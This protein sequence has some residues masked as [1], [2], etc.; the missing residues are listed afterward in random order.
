[1]SRD[2]KRAR[3]DASGA[4][5]R[6]LVAGLRVFDRYYLKR[7]LGQGGMGVV[8]LAHDRVLEQPVALKFLAEE[9]FHDHHEV[10]RLKHETRRNL[11]LT[12]P[13]IV[14]IHDFV[15]D[16]HGA[17][18]AM[19]YVD[20]WSLWAMKVD[21]PRQVFDVSELQ[22]WIRDLCGALE[23]AH[24]EAN[25]VHRD[26]K[27]A[28]LLLNSRGQLKVTDFGL[29]RDIRPTGAPDPA[30]PRI[31]GT[32][33]YMGPQQWTGEAPAVAD[34]IYSLGVTI[35]ELLTGNPPFYEGDVFKQLFEM[36]PPTMTERLHALGIEDV[37]I[38][39]AWEETV[40]ACLAKEA[41]RRPV[42]AREVAVRLGLM[43]GA[44]PVAVVPPI[45]TS[46]RTLVP[47]LPAAQAGAPETVV[48]APGEAA[49]AS[50]SGRPRLAALISERARWLAA[51]AAGW[52]ADRRSVRVGAAL[53]AGLLVISTV[54]VA[55]RHLAKSRPG[56]AGGNAPSAPLPAGG[57]WQNSLGMKF[58]SIPGTP[59][60]FS[61]WETRV[62]DFDAFV[63]DTGYDIGHDLFRLNP[64]G[65][66]RP[67]G[68]SWRNP[69]F[70]QTTNSPVV[71]VTW[72]DAEKFCEWLTARERKLGVL[73][74]NQS[75]RLPRLTEWIHAAGT[76]LY[77]WGDD[78]PPPA[79]AGNYAGTELLTMV[80]NHQVISG[81]QD[82]FAGTAPVGSFK[83]N[84]FGIYDLGGNVWEFCADGPAN[85][86]N[87][88]WMMGGSWADFAKAAL[89]VSN[90]ARGEGAKRYSHRG[91][92]CVLAVN[93][94]GSA[95]RP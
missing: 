80:T 13:N 21:K 81:Y 58:V 30:H 18:I 72:R 57:S 14:R 88:R 12:H 34:D 45:E 92:R 93:E 31:V 55:G 75:Y 32:D 27:P 43:E 6:A 69:D 95:S 29:S 9:L 44:K 82:G 62:Q 36:M 19:E 89:S 35:Y 39:L 51:L 8:W 4:N 86:P 71:G 10:E 87:A 56:S 63:R 65:Q 83:P 23:Y 66:W 49:V 48:S 46:R 74:T 40:A 28:N 79:G 64:A 24:T 73:A 3:P 53:M 94:A 7:T 16:A 1:M 37:V 33:L 77:P 52:F 54:W 2:G 22:S 68:N 84:A 42:S 47:E 59:V 60:L 38:P 26:L 41:D 15:Q 61:V 20:G 67:T 70:P 50:A 78:W 90:R 25:I 11:K 76:G 17:A 85:A 91:F 5:P